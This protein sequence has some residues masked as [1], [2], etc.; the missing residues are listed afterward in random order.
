MRLGRKALLMGG[1][2]VVV[3]TGLLLGPR[4]LRRVKA[5]LRGG[6]A[7]HG[8]VAAAFE[9]PR[10]LAQPPA[11][12]L[13]SG[14]LAVWVAPD[15]VKVLPD[16]TLPRAPGGGA[17]AFATSFPDYRNQSAAWSADQR[18]ARVAALRGETVALSVVVEARG[19]ALR[20]V[21]VR[22]GDF[23]GELGRTLPA[24]IA[25]LSVAHH[26][27]VVGAS[28]AD[29]KVMLGS[30]GPGDYPDPLVP[31]T[32][33]SGGLPMVI[34]RFGPIGPDPRNRGQGLC[35]L[36]S[37]STS[38]STSTATSTLIE[39]EIVRPGAVGEATYRTREAG[40]AWSPAQPTDLTTTTGDLTLEWQ[41]PR[42]GA[43]RAGDR[44]ELTRY[45]AFSQP[46]W[47]DL[48]IP[49]DAAP[50]RYR[51]PVDIRAD[52]VP[53]LSFTL[54]LTV[55]PGVLGPPPLLTVA[56]VYRQDLL[57]GENRDQAY[58]DEASWPLERATYRLLR[59]HGIDAIFRE[60]A[61]EPAD[62]GTVAPAEWQRFDR[63]W[64]SA[65]D[66]SAFPDGRP[67]RAFE[68]PLPVPD[69]AAPPAERARQD[70]RLAA[71]ARAWT[72]HLAAR[73]WLDRA[74]AYPI[75]EPDLADYDHV[76]AV[77]R[78]IHDASAGRLPILLTEQP[79]PL[80]PVDNWY[81]D[82]AERAHG[83]DLYTRTAATPVAIWAV[84]GQLA[85]PGADPANSSALAIDRVHERG[86]RWWLYQLGEPW[87]GNTLIDDD[88]PAFTTWGW[89]AFRY[90][91]DALFYYAVSH[92]S[93][94]TYDFDNL[95]GITEN[96]ATYRGDDL[97]LNGDGTLLYPG[98]P[99]G[100]AAPI[101]SLRMKA[102][103]RGI[104]DHT[105]LTAFAALRGAPAADAEAARLI[106][107]ALNR[108][109]PG[110]PAAL[111]T[112]K[113]ARA[114]GTWSRNAWD[115]ES[116]RTT[117]RQQLPAPPPPAPTPAPPPAGKRPAKP[118]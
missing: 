36:A 118:R 111:P 60:P 85:F 15:G 95:A 33:P 43:Y 62:D 25:E 38:T 53:A 22:V 105:L 75:D 34:S 24:A 12:R 112:W 101:A 8:V 47:I 57:L 72:E 97:L 83:P 61:L 14:A 96:P 27:R 76:A 3:T 30:T 21:D 46:I 5:R 45:P 54:E 86:A 78:T 92:Y 16:G 94:A 40:A 73:G 113:T 91:P 50:G 29:G 28:Y 10:A 77:I 59:A 56:R 79:Y 68:V 52:G 13:A 44:F 11:P 116:A 104:Q 51:A 48:A 49:P 7:S 63:T 93:Q 70:A 84:N 23:G 82:A 71:A 2:L 67:L 26:L 80:D 89:I 88:L 58:A 103:R 87:L 4:V 39:L 110:T 1:L 19:A 32:A 17:G 42:K 106:P 65:L 115:Y 102:L 99:Y 114:P 90:R 117:L 9:R 55:H 107:R 108:F 109:A 66:G 74:F 37:T 6:A 18:Q 64:G 31:A 20:G 35:R 98:A 100:L 41:P 81:T 69:A